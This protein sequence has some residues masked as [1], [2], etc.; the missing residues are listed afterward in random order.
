[1]RWA[2]CSSSFWAGYVD[3]DGCLSSVECFPNRWGNKAEQRNETRH[4]DKDSDV[5][6]RRQAED[7]ENC[8]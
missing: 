6:N 4:N 7:A 8:D 5:A 2:S 1:M 3:C